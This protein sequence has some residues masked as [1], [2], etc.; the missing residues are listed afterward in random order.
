M[1]LPNDINMVVSILNMK[2]RDD[3]MSL[4]M[5]IDNYDEVYD[6]VIKKLEKNGFEYNQSLRQIKVK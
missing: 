3:D 2:L 4:E 6:E 5:I 1:A